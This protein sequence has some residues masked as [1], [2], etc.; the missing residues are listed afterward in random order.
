[1]NVGKKQPFNNFVGKIIFRHADS[2]GND[3][4]ISFLKCKPT[5]TFVVPDIKDEVSVNISD[6]L[7]KLPNMVVQK[8]TSRTDSLFNFNINLSRYNIPI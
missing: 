5:C 7:L 2:Q 8:G 4:L 6:I 3:F 1:M